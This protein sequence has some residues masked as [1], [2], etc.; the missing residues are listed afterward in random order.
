MYLFILWGMDTPGRFPTIFTKNITFDI[1]CLLSVVPKKKNPSEKESTLEG[2]N[3]LFFQRRPFSEG[4]RMKVT[5]PERASIPITLQILT[6]H[7]HDS[8]V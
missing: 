5:S 1:S 2:N 3:L 7:I 6:S 8:C 4:K